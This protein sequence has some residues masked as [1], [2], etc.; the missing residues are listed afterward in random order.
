MKEEIDSLRKLIN[1]HF[2]IRIT[3]IQQPKNEVRLVGAGQLDKYISQELTL[4]LFKKALD[5]PTEIYTKKLR[6]SRKIEFV[7]K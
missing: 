3:F 7:S 2:L 6:K 1:K 4:R 5:C